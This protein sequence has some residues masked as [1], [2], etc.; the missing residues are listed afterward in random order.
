M[1][2]LT[3]QL[4]LPYLTL[5]GGTLLVMLAVSIRRQHSVAFWASI[6]VI[7]ASILVHF[8]GWPALQPGGFEILGQAMIDGFACFFNVLFLVAALITAI[9]AQPYLEQTSE[10]REEFYLLLLTATLGAMVMVTATN[11]IPFI[12]GLEILSI[13]LYAMIAYPENEA[14]STRGFD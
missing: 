5:A 12:L 6:I 2:A 3:L 11:F 4:G 7:L 1:D 8:Y 13:S 14:S 9:L 10:N